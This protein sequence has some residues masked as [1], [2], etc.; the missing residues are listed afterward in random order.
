MENL[1]SVL[2]AAP[3]RLREGARTTIPTRVASRLGRSAEPATLEEALDA[4]EVI[5]VDEEAPRLT[6]LESLAVQMGQLL[7]HVAKPKPASEAPKGGKADPK[8]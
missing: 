2:G 7:T 5:S 3:G 4:D 6:Q 1:R 8:A